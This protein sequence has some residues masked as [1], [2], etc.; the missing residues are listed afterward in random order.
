MA[1]FA[2]SLYFLMYLLSDVLF[3][4]PIYWFNFNMTYTIYPHLYIYIYTWA[5]F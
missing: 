5:M 3:Y 4:L 2:N 1:I